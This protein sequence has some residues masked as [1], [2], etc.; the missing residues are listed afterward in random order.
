[1]RLDD[2]PNLILL[3]RLLKL[4][5]TGQVSNIS[6]DPGACLGELNYVSCE[7]SSN[8]QRQSYRGHSPISWL[9]LF[10]L[11]HKSDSRRQRQASSSMFDC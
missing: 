3:K 2:I 10:V 7:K 1:M 4:F 8:L 5:E 9:G 11:Q 6:T